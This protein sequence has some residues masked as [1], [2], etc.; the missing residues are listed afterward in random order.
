MTQY[1]YALSSEEHPPLE[2]VKHARLAEDAGLDF[3]MISD[4]FHPWTSAQGNSPFVW[5]VI[6]GIAATTDR[7]GV[8][9]GVTCPTM[10]IHPA[11]IAHAS[12]TA[13]AMLPG[14]FYLGVGSGEAL[15]EHVL[16]DPWPSA[17][18]RVDMLE[19]AIEVIRELWTGEEVSFH[20]A[21]YTVDRARLFTVPETLPPICVASASPSAA[22]LAGQNDGLVATSPDSEVMAEFEGAGGSGKPRFGQVTVCWDPNI[23]EARRIAA[24]T[25]RMSAL[26]WKLKTEITTPASFD[27]VCEFVSDDDALASTKTGNSAGFIIDAIREFETAGFDHIY[28][29]QIGPRQPEFLRLVSEEVLPELRRDAQHRKAS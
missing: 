8:G 10:R 25:W 14:R 3:A 4:H 16:G 29:H 17:A 13:A 6:G 1:G 12:A 27:A 24:E 22:R 7:L 9:T 23:E 11:I 15:N 26:S 20:G 18:M 21:H 2:L 28:V 5:S 19:E